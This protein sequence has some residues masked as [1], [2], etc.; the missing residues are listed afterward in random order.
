MG[1]HSHNGNG[2]AIYDSPNMTGVATCRLRIAAEVDEVMIVSQFTTVVEQSGSSAASLMWMVTT[3]VQRVGPEFGRDL[4]SDER[5][6]R[7]G[8]QS[9]LVR[10]QVE[11]DGTRTFRPGETDAQP[12][13]EEGVDVAPT[14]HSEHSPNQAPSDKGGN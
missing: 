13:S 6:V 3:S 8:D 7:R 5:L 12:A 4:T 14:G 10:R 1:Y 9:F 2:A 11:L